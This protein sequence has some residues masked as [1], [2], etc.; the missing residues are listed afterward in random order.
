MF[1]SVSHA[2]FCSVNLLLDVAKLIMVISSFFGSR[3]LDSLCLAQCVLTTRELLYLYLFHVLEIRNCEAAKHAPLC[4][5]NRQKILIFFIPNIYLINGLNK[6]YTNNFGHIFLKQ[7][8][9][10]MWIGFYFDSL[11]WIMLGWVRKMLV[12]IMSHEIETD[13]SQIWWSVDL[14]L[15]L[16]GK[17]WKGNENV[18]RE[19]GFWEEKYETSFSFFKCTLRGI[20]TRSSLV[21]RMREGSP[22]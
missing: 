16:M 20:I 8:V 5:S 22:L 21:L 3:G 15:S 14:K 18:T 9:G 13:Q 11:A 6:F 4:S 7:Q 12:G 10:L 2:L 17:H 1:S 19:R